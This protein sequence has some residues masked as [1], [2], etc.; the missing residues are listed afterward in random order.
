[1]GYFDDLK[2]N[3]FFF[4]TIISKNGFYF[5]LFKSVL[6]KPLLKNLS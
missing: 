6:S 5:L 4:L 3:S 2:E 1:M